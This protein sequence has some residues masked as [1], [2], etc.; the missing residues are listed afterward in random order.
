MCRETNAA[1]Q[2][3]RK[4]EQAAERNELEIRYERYRG[5]LKNLTLMSDVF[6]RNVFKERACTEYV[7]Q[8][9]MGRKDLKV[10]AQVLQKD[11]KNLQGRS[12]VLDCVVQDGDGR[13][14]D[15][16]IQQDTEGAS[17]K[18][19][20]YHSGLVDMNTLKNGEDFDRLPETHVIFITRDD[21]LGYGL[22][23][24]HIEKRIKEVDAAFRDEAYI[25]Y[26]NSRRQE[27]TEL[28]R[29][30]HDFHCRDAKD[31]HSEILARRVHE[32]KETQEGVEFM[33]R[34]MDEIYREGELRGELRGEKRGEER[35]RVKGRREGQAE[36]ALSLANMGIPVEQIAEA[37]KVSVSLVQEWLS[38]NK[39][40]AK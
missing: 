9:I 11:Y 39:E 17:P 38:G 15:V 3:E 14:F 20:R 4:D 16:E 13:Q 6:M 10:T 28:G 27:D 5:I 37:A 31:I 2:E 22:P 18:R 12:A 33:C 34:E 7:L 1:A 35:G 24:Y 29:L 8:V 26:V 21:V 25:I 32:L 19:A 30:M 40:I 23:I 36:M